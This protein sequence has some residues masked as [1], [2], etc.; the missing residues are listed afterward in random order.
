MLA[1]RSKPRAFR[2]REGLQCFNHEIPLLCSAC[3][4]PTLALPAAHNLTSW[5][6]PPLGAA[7]RLKL[8]SCLKLWLLHIIRCQL[9]D[10]QVVALCHHLAGD[11][12]RGS[13]GCTPGRAAGRAGCRAGA[14]WAAG[15]LHWGL[16]LRVLQ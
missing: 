2:V 13:L 12:T 7:G 1:V 6:P 10:S 8:P 5:S 9:L 14:L 15:R 11:G 3:R 16:C 4:G